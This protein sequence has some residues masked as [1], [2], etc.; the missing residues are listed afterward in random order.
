MSYL[1][2]LTDDQWAVLEP[3]F[4]ERAAKKRYVG[5]R[6]RRLDL[7]QIMNALLYQVRTGCQWRMLPQEFPA[8]QTVRYYFDQWNADGTLIA[9]NDVLR[10]QVRHADGGA[11]EPTAGSLDSQSTKT[12]ESGGDRGYDGGKKVTGRNRHIAVDTQGNLLAVVVHAANISDRDGAWDVLDVLTRRCPTIRNLWVDGGYIGLSS[13][14][15]RDY[16]VRLEVVRKHPDQHTFEVLPRRW[17][18]E[19]TCAWLGRARILS[20]EYTRCEEYTESW[21][22]LSSIQRMVNK[23]H[24]NE[25]RM[26]RYH[27][28][29]IPRTVAV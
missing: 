7:R 24:P 17:V 11:A 2:D 26:T 16:G 10:R 28:R 23:L 25:T 1:T 13:V 5:G 6:P 3:L 21:I 29:K 4:A 18:V 15:E 8:W 20:K 12:T 19:R 14:I 22:Y 9:M 27:H